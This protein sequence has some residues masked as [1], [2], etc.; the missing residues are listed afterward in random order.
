MG[1]GTDHALPLLGHWAL[2]SWTGE[3]TAGERVAH[4]GSA[5]RGD[6]I[7]LPSGRM[8]VQIAHDGR[9]RFGSRDLGAGDEA[10]RAA[11]YSTYIAYA[12][13]FSVPEPGTVVHHVEQALHPDQT[14]M[15]KCRSYDLD[16]DVLIL[17]TQ[18]VVA[19]GREA[20]S[21][22]HWRRRSSF[23]AGL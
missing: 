17:R 20:S 14:G 16:A 19:D 7:Y 3:T 22:L 18:P 8:A 12:G 2:E 6:L 23:A 1:D 5:P 10:G 4:G 9:T 11:A 15:D 13:R 21:E